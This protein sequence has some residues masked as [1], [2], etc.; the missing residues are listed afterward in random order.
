MRTERTGFNDATTHLT[1]A[2]TKQERFVDVVVRFYRSYTSKTVLQS[3]R[4][5]QSTVE[6][7]CYDCRKPIQVDINKFLQ[8]RRFNSTELFCQEH[9]PKDYD[10][11]RSVLF[12]RYQDIFMKTLTNKILSTSLQPINHDNS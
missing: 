6:W 11:L 5:Q 10:V 7:H 8:G 12:I 4:K 9:K 3:L 1:N 2:M